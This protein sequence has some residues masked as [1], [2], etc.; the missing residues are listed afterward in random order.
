MLLAK[1]DRL[2]LGVALVLAVAS[3]LFAASGA[4]AGKRAARDP[5][6]VAAGDIACD[7]ADPMFNGGFGRSRNC[8]MRQTSDLVL[9]ARPSAV[10]TLGDNQYADGALSKFARSYEPTW[11]RFKALTHPA[12]GNHDYA[13]ESSA[14]YFDYFDG[15]GHGNGRAGPRG[16]GYYSF[17]LGQWHIVSLNANC[18][19]SEVACSWKSRQARWLREDLAENRRQCVLAFAGRPRFSS[20]ETGHYQPLRDL[21]KILYRRGVDVLLSGDSHNYERFAPLDP[22]GQPSSHGIRQFVVGTGGKNLSRFK[23]PILAGSEATSADGFGVLA[24]QLHPRSYEWQFIPEPGNP[25]RDAG[26]R[27]CR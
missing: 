19:L 26:G 2:N 5:V 25:F 20:T 11:G 8:H 22:S 13:G 10:L 27:A 3:A 15:A 21:F 14:G 1:R 18:E 23:G 6:I 12:I 24:I 4:S 7:P 16:R 9:A 17:N